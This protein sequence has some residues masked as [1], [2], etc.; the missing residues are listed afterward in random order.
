MSPARNSASPQPVYYSNPRREEERLSRSHRRLTELKESAEKTDALKKL[1]KLQKTAASR[2]GLAE[3]QKSK[4]TPL[5]E[6]PAHLQE[7][8]SVEEPDNQASVSLMC[9]GDTAQDYFF[10]KIHAMLGTLPLSSEEKEE[11][12]ADLISGK[13]LK[14]HS[15]AD[16]INARLREKHKLDVFRYWLETVKG[17]KLLPAAEQRPVAEQPIR[18]QGRPRIIVCRDNPGFIA[19]YEGCHICYYEESSCY[20]LAASGRKRPQPTKAELKKLKGDLVV[21]ARTDQEL[22]KYISENRGWYE[23]DFSG[24]DYFVYPLLEELTITYD[25]YAI[26]YNGIYR[27]YVIERE[28]RTQYLYPKHADNKDL[29]DQFKRDANEAA[30]WNPEVSEYLGDY[31]LA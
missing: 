8:L 25:S 10:R 30:S 31:R 2:N 22:N 13:A 24:S 17:Q 28:G 5:I 29:I 9:P 7:P 23:S 19:F 20:R 21:E 16:C 15:L 12:A 11:L 18:N 4:P 27:Y 3:T 14:H 6:L 26:K 1:A